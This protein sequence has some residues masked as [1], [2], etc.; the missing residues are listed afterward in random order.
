M[1]FSTPSAAPA[2]NCS[3]ELF[4]RDIRDDVCIGTGDLGIPGEVGGRASGA[5]LMECAPRLW[6]NRLVVMFVTVSAL[7]PLPLCGRKVGLGNA[8]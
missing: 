8:D 7:N 5:E 2:T 4:A 1:S 3:P 6:W